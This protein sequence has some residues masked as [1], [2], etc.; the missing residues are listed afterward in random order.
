MNSL[1]STVSKGKTLQQKL[2]YRLGQAGIKLLGAVTSDQ[3][4]ELPRDY[5]FDAHIFHKKF[6]STHYGVMI[7]DLPEPY[8]YLSYASVIGDVGAKITQ[9]SKK[10]TDYKPEN[11]ATLV[12]GTALSHTSDA[13][14][15]YSISEQ[16]KFQQKPFQVKYADDSSLTEVDEGFHLVSNSDHLHVDIILKSTEALTWFAHSIF[17]QHFSVLMQYEGT[18]RQQG[19]TVEVKGLC[20]LEHWKAISLSMFPQ[21]FLPKNAYLPLTAF[22][23]QV[24]NLNDQEQLVLAF[25]GFASQPAYTAV[26]YRH[27]DGTSIQYDD[28]IF[29]VI[30]LKVE[31]EVT[32]D[33]FAMEVPQ[34]FQWIV[35]HDNQKILDMIAVVD[36]PYCYGLAAGYVSAYHWNGEF[37]QQKAEGRGYLEYIDR[38]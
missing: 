5:N 9:T 10:L 37:N 28:A 8:R 13:F 38:R 35:H 23:Y 21:K 15:I 24:I 17:Y 2:E 3:Q 29:K 1:L 20:T 12:H 36:T 19:K 14:K 11:T 32:P 22:S 26:S 25:V 16:L 4:N 31:P 34:S 18:I 27:V 33:G 7:P 30:A 6:A